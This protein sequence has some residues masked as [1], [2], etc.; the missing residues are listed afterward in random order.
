MSAITV[1]SAKKIITMNPARPHATHVAV[2]DGKVL[3]TGTIDEIAGWGNYTLDD[4][5]ADKVIMPGLVEG[6][7]PFD[8]RRHM[9]I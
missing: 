8:G 6:T 1:F 5:F 2:K 4:S 9:A 3:A 7:L